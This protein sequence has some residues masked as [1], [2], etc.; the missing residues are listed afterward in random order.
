MYASGN[1]SKAIADNTKSI[2][3]IFGKTIQ[4]RYL[5]I[6]LN[7]TEMTMIKC[8]IRDMLHFS[9]PSAAKKALFRTRGSS[10]GAVGLMQLMPNTARVAN[11]LVIP[12]RGKMLSRH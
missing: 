5:Y 8:H 11:L 4:S 1:Y 6:F 12:N 9:W 10:A 7:L 3:K 2:M